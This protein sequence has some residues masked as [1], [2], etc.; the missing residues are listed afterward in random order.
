M[1]N[2]AGKSKENI[3]TVTCK[4]NNVV[5]AGER[6]NNYHGICGTVVVYITEH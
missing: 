2:S 4:H 1:Q 5:S 3:Q 6:E